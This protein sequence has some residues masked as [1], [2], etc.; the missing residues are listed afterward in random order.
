FFQAEDG[1]R[2]FHVTGVQTCA[3]PISLRVA[4]VEAH[5]REDGRYTRHAPMPLRRV[6][7]AYRP[8]HVLPA[9]VELVR[10]LVA[11]AAA[12]HVGEDAVI[13]SSGA[14]TMLEALLATGRC[15]W[16]TVG[17][18]LTRG[19]ARKARPAWRVAADGSQEIDWRLEPAADH[20]L[21]LEP[22]WYLDV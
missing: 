16:Q 2:D 14:A 6:L 19:E 17:S 20:V 21:A 18:K 9:D 5:V 4:L 3:L 11:D 13:W 22:P 10:R 15:H 8:P 1:I 7:D 12:G